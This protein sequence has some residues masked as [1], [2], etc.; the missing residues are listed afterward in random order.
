MK[1]KK[2]FATSKKEQK[3]DEKGKQKVSAIQGNDVDLNDLEIE[4]DVG[5]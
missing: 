1:K 3:K 4:N 2:K 5:T